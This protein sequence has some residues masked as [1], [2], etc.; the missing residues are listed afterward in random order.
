MDIS[1]EQYKSSINEL[2]TDD[3]F[4][5]EDIIAGLEKCKFVR[6]MEMLLTLIIKGYIMCSIQYNTKHFITN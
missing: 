6:T 1:I 4:V 5:M 2:I 3:S